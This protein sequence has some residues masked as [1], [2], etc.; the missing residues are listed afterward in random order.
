M[1]VEG[2][3]AHA[4]AVLPHEVVEL[5]RPAGGGATRIPALKCGYREL[6]SEAS[7][8]PVMSQVLITVVSFRWLTDTV[9]YCDLNGFCASISVY[10]KRTG[11]TPQS[12]WRDHES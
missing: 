3:R 7:E 4:V 5:F 9:T 8:L 1:D 2:E 11:V 12:D 6:A 10:V